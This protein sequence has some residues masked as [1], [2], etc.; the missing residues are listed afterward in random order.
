MGEFFRVN[1][2][3]RFEK[4]AEMTLLGGEIHL[5][6]FH[7]GRCHILS[8]EDWLAFDADPVNSVYPIVKGG[9][10]HSVKIQLGKPGSPLNI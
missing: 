6:G 5:N 1:T 3:V 9:F 2:S 8:S 7:V 10:I 4:S